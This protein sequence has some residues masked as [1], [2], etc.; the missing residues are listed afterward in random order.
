MLSAGHQLSNERCVKSVGLCPKIPSEDECLLP[1]YEK[2]EGEREGGRGR[3]KGRDELLTVGYV[4]D[5][6]NW[7]LAECMDESEILCFHSHTHPPIR[8]AHL[9]FLLY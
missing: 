5:K 6:K 9:R 7:K 2:R 3:G 4:K 8:P 1:E